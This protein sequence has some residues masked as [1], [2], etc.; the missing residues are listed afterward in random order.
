VKRR[1]GAHMMTAG[2]LRRAIETGAAV[3]CDVVQVFTKSPQQWQA[4]P[5]ADADVDAFRRAQEE[6]GIPCVA[7]HDSYLINPAAA[8]PAVLERSRA[9]LGEEL[10][11]A[12]RLGIPA[13]V[14]H[15]G[16]AGEAPEE[17]AL[18]RLIESVRQSFERAAV[19]EAPW[20]LLETT[21]GQGTTLGYRFE[22]IAA[23]LQAIDGA[24]THSRG[25]PL[26]V[27]L[28]TCHVFAAGYELRDAAGYEETMAAFDRLIGRER[29][30]L[31]HANDS[32][33]ERGSRVD[34]HQ[35][36]GQGEIGPEGF[37][38]LVNDPRLVEVPIILETPKKGD[39]DPVNLAA[40][41]G[42]V[43]PPGLG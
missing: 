32:L 17:E 43:A 34:R 21:A 38:L 11:R 12:A 15:L 41:R 3:G 28:D 22:Q 20:L 24:R 1:F 27:C 39:M 30:R 37:R 36:I 7:A 13:V 4:R 6:S 10:G 14:M 23:V 40:L 33:R 16:A 31:I 18:E 26:G 5:L 8:D 9:A 2:G 35:H 25:Y 29:L 19:E 42:L